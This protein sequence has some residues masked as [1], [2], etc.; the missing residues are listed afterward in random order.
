MKK[1]FAGLFAV[2]I[3]K[4]AQS[5]NSYQSAVELFE[6]T[7]ATDGLDT[8]L[9]KLSEAPA[10]SSGV[11]SLHDKLGIPPVGQTALSHDGK[12]LF[13]CLAG[14]I[15]WVDAGFLAELKSSM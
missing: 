10:D 9:I 15:Y 6:R 1:L 5:S 11:G 13:S 14:D 3:L 12:Y 4:A 7:L 2:A 8:A